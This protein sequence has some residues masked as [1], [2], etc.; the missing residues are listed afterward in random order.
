[1]TTVHKTLKIA[2][3][4]VGICDTLMSMFR[5]GSKHKQCSTS[6]FSAR[7][8]S[9]FRKSFVYILTN[10]SADTLLSTVIFWYTSKIIK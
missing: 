10:L 2:Q 7:M 1:M 4:N 3:N 9:G 5:V 8:D 6:I